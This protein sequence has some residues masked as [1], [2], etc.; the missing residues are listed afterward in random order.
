MALSP[1]VKIDVDDDQFQKFSA[2]FGAYHEKLKAM[3]ADWAKMNDRISELA[4][5]QMALGVSADKAWSHAMAASQ[6]YERSV[7]ASVAAQ[8]G[9]GHA[10]GQTALAMGR[11]AGAAKGIAGHLF[12]AVRFG[13]RLMGL[14]GIG[15]GVLGGG[16]LFGLD[17]MADDV[18]E[19]HRQARGLG[20]T[21]GQVSAYKLNLGRYLGMG[22]L[23][24]ASTAQIDQTK[25]GYLAGLGINPLTARRESAS[26]LVG[27]EALAIHRMWRQNPSLQSRGAIMAQ[28]LGYTPADIR[29]LGTMHGAT[30]RG[31]VAADANT[32]GLS[33]SS[34]SAR[35]WAKFSIAL[36]K[37]GALI[38]TALINTLT[39][40]TPG[41]AMLARRV[42][43]L[44]T[45][46]EK[47]GEVKEWVADL[48]VGLK[49]FGRWLGSP[50]FHQDMRTIAYYFGAIADKVG[51]VARWIVGPM[52]A[53][54]G[55][56]NPLNEKN[57]AGQFMG[58]KTI[59]SG[60]RHNYR[61]MERYPAE[62]HAATIADMIGIWNGHGA[63]TAQYIRR[64]ARWAHVNPN[65]PVPFGNDAKMAA[66]I[67]AMSKEEGR[68]Y[69]TPAEALSAIKK[70]G[71][72][73][74]LLQAEQ[75][76]GASGMA[77]S[78]ALAPG[79]VAQ[80]RH[81]V[82]AQAYARELANA[83]PRQ[84]AVAP[85]RPPIG[86]IIHQRNRHL[87]RLGLKV[88]VQNHTG[89]NVHVGVNAAGAGFGN[90]L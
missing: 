71:T 34:A 32:A 2:A 27:Q 23:S 63:N 88:T 64:V 41:L 12:R 58:F 33:I 40:L 86:S 55:E 79:A 67:S 39:P 82:A 16:L 5:T 36:T 43:D 81:S 50:S 65:A 25:W 80:I 37:A 28:G 18:L 48:G 42:A 38:D 4:K 66:I 44:I 72:R 8:K 30:L 61:L 14:L 35:A 29:M 77:W 13:A 1:V 76:A 75:A 15:T 60:I 85:A 87:S 54:P 84:P 59:G 17:T 62:H 52:P 24:A 7:R 70:V 26:A 53:A 21:M 19:R 31:L 49:E 83:H 20:M 47:S 56:N 89:A 69:V 68:H 78:G 57:A 22:A 51:A 46:L 90:Q 74:A 73:R 45:G 11:V 9:L 10:A 6:S 3:P